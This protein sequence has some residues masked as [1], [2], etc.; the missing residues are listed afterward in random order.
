MP[1]SFYVYFLTFPQNKRSTNTNINPSHV[2]QKLDLGHNCTKD[3]LISE[4]VFL[5]L[6][7]LQSLQSCERKCF[8]ATSVSSLFWGCFFVSFVNSTSDF[9]SVKF[10][11]QAPI[12]KVH[13]HILY[14]IS[15]INLVLRNPKAVAPIRKSHHSGKGVPT[16]IQGRITA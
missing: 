14:R 4:Q 15:A 5:L 2:L 9:R 11:A 13:I 6:N 12:S 10:I 8:P 1:S 16:K 3:K 7:S